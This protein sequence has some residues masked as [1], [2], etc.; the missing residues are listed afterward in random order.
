[1]LNIDQCCRRNINNLPDYDKDKM[2]YLESISGD[3]NSII[4]QAI[5]KAGFGFKDEL[6]IISKLT[7]YSTVIDYMDLQQEYVKTTEKCY[8]EGDCDEIAEIVIPE[9]CFQKYRK[10]I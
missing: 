4:T 2:R 3:I 5:S 6:C 10:I 1:M 8:E 7:G 9:N